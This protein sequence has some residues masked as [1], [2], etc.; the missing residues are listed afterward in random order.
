MHFHKESFVPTGKKKLMQQKATQVPISGEWIKKLLY[1]Y[2]Q[3]NITQPQKD[4]DSVDGP[5]GHGTQ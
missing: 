2:M 4:G 5:R 3:W 1:K